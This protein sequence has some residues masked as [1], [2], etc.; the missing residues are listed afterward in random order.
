MSWLKHRGAVIRPGFAFLHWALL[1]MNDGWSPKITETEK[2]D[3]LSKQPDT[4]FTTSASG[5]L[6]QAAQP[7]D[8]FAPSRLGA[9]EERLICRGPNDAALLRVVSIASRAGGAEWL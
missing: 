8:D 4:F 2:D 5:R 3:C 1:S 9:G 6:V 7:D